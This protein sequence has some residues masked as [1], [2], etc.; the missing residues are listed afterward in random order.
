MNKYRM[1]FYPESRFGGFADIDGTVV[2]YSRVNA[3]I[4]PSFVV[5]DFGC[6]R[7][8]RHR[9]D[10]IS[11][12]RELQCLKGK[13]TRVVGVDVDEVGRTNN[14]IDEFRIL[15]PGRPWPVDDRSVDMIIC[16]WVIEHLPDPVAFFSE[17][18]RV[19]VAGGYLCI[20]TPNAYG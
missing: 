8:Y 18:R 6:G 3:L 13:V 15:T 7:G 19:L 20:R 1:M 11:F 9:E 4:Q 10:S 17:A 5:L 16:D 14:G 2:F 12:R